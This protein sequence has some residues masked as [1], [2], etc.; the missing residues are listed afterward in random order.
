MVF[1]LIEGVLVEDR[2]ARRG[3]TEDSGI[4]VSAVRL[5]EMRPVPDGRRDCKG[6]D[7]VCVRCDGLQD[8]DT[9]N[10]FTGWVQVR[11]HK[12]PVAT[13]HVT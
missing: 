9:D 10:R 2:E 6:L 12:V 13:T 4:G 3:S 5:R 11:L 1:V 8:G 7:I